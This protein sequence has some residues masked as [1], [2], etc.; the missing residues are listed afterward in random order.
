M[1]RLIG[2]L[3]LPVGLRFLLHGWNHIAKH[4]GEASVQAWHAKHT[5]V[6]REEFPE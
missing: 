6:I 5:Q 3:L 4:I 1:R 2:V